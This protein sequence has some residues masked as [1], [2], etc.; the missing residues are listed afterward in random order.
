[1]KVVLTTTYA[2]K[3]GEN[4]LRQDIQKCDCSQRLCLIH[5]FPSP[6]SLVLDY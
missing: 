5:N 1:M 4:L 6:A 2:T 3:A